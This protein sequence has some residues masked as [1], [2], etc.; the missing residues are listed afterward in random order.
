MTRCPPHRLCAHRPPRPAPPG[1]LRRLRLP[2]VAAV[3]AAIGTALPTDGTHRM[4]AADSGKR[5]YV[6]DAATAG[7]SAVARRSANS[8]GDQTWTLG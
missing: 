4:S 3:P 7:G 1:A 8:G 5:L 6:K 2:V